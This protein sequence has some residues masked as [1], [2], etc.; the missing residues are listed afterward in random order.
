ML[1]ILLRTRMEALLSVLTGAS[2]TKK[3]QSKGKLI[4]FATLMILSLFSLGT[5]FARIFEVDVERNPRR[6]NVDVSVVAVFPL[7]V[8]FDRADF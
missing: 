7:V 5:L 6:L 1:K 3:A 8:P 2:R 4:G